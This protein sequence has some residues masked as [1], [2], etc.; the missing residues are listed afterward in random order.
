MWDNE[1]TMMNLKN[2][3]KSLKKLEYLEA[4]KDYE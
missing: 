4:K 2:Q 3:E 1:C